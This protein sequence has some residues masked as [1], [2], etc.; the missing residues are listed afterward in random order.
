MV[1]QHVRHEA[2]QTLLEIAR[3][4]RYYNAL[5][6]RYNRY[7]LCLSVLLGVS[8]AGAVVSLVDLLPD[9]A[10]WVRIWVPSLQ[11]RHSELGGE[12]KWKGC[13]PGRGLCS[14]KST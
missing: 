11:G 4:A 7:R 6:T 10:F 9:P 8:G 1:S 2:S 14:V 12:S 3:V 13:S 5:S